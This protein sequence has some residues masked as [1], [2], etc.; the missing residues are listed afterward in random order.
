M[1]KRTEIQLSS[2]YISLHSLQTFN[3]NLLLT[4]LCGCG[5]LSFISFYLNALVVHERLRSVLVEAVV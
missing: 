2:H 5:C 4:K 1:K 3:P